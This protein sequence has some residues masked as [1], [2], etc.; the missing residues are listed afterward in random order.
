V[1]L[2][3]NVLGGIDGVR[4][5][6][7]VA[8]MSRDL[9]AT[10]LGEFRIDARQSPELLESRSGADVNAVCT[11]S[12][13]AAYL[14]VTAAT[15]GADALAAARRE[16]RF[17]HDIAQSAPVR[18]PRLLDSMDTADGVAIL[19]EA[20]GRAQDVTSWTPGMWADLGRD[21]ARLHSMP[22]PPGTEWKRPDA[23][24]NAIVAP[25]LDEITSFWAPTL[26][27]LADVIAHRDDLADQ[28]HALPPAFIHG[29]CH[30]DNILHA[31]G[32]LIFCDWQTTGIGRP[33]SDLAFLSVR[34]APAGVTVPQALV[35]AYLHHRLCERDTLRWALLAEELAILVFLWPPY[36]VFNSRPRIARIRQRA[37][38]LAEH[39]QRAV[40]ATPR[41]AGFTRPLGPGANFLA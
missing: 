30:T 36:A 15:A 27:Q 25:K 4:H 21:L 29:D 12:G 16:L 13:R 41:R 40:I 9:V 31:A 28:I 20:A 3:L 6:G 18:T 17:Y 23:L 1:R 22:L 7:V 26:P 38:E 33:M 32:A 19:L 35:E 2:H 11:T 37:G 8:V 10:V 34:S 5:L 24:H 39:W 14:K